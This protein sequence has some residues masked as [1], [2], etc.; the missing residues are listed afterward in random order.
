MGS[1]DDAS[2]REFQGSI[3]LVGR[4]WSAAILL[5]LARGAQRFGELHHAVDGISSRLLAVRLKELEEE[6]L[7]QRTVIPTTP[8]EIRYTLTE[9]GR[10]LL[11]GLMPLIHW[12]QRWRVGSERRA[13]QA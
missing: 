9:S 7:L 5:A 4:K 11:V 2:C 8:V 3:E 12:Q 13:E 1:I 6:K 10:E